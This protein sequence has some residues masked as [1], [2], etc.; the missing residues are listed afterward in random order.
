[1]RE[2]VSEIHA[3]LSGRHRLSVYRRLHVLYLDRGSISTEWTTKDDATLKKLIA[4]RG[5]KWVSIGE[6]M[7]RSPEIVR[8]RYKDYVSLGEKRNLGKWDEGDE[9]RLLQIVHTLLRKSEWQTGEGYDVD[10][11]SKYV[12]WGVVSDKVGTR[13]R[14]QCRDK[15]KYWNRIED[16]D[17]LGKMQRLDAWHG[18]REVL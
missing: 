4:E 7:G 18:K 1:M 10:V 2:L 11:M 9:N 14:L 16:F 13:S 5:R 6:A 12:D 3:K 8:L 17:F 15:W